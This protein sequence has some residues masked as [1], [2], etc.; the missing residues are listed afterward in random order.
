MVNTYC[1]KSLNKSQTDTEAGR[2]TDMG[3]EE[4]QAPTC[5]RSRLSFS[6]VQMAFLMVRSSL[7]MACASASL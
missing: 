3:S 6:P 5:I 1:P 7:M 2:R 4:R